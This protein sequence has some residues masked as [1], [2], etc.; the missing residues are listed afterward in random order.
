M[1]HYPV[2]HWKIT[3]PLTDPHFTNGET[4]ARKGQRSA[5]MFAALLGPKF[6]GKKNFKKNQSTYSSPACWV[7]DRAQGFHCEV[8]GPSGIPRAGKSWKTLTP[9]HQPQP[10]K[11]SPGLGKL[12]ASVCHLNRNKLESQTLKKR[13][14]KE[15]KKN[16]SKIKIKL[17]NCSC[18]TPSHSRHISPCSL[19]CIKSSQSQTAPQQRDHTG[20]SDGAM[21]PAL[22]Q[23]GWLLSLG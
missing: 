7:G 21:S 3:T 4:E 1:K 19:G 11:P 10:E 18:K 14:Q 13:D 2:K 6:K 17:E 16:P 23:R 5:T 15:K 8:K 9:K 22:P 12:K 20:A